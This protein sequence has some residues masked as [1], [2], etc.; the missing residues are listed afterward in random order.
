MGSLQGPI[1]CLSVRAKQTGVHPL[2]VNGPLMKAKI[3]RS[4]FW[5][6]RG[7]N[8][9]RINVCQQLCMQMYKKVQCSFSSSSNGNGSM[10]ENFNENDEDYVNSSI[11]EVGV[12]NV[13]VTIFYFLNSV[14]FNAFVMFGSAFGKCICLSVILSTLEEVKKA[15]L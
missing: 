10:V 14:V 8:G 5:G 15:N 2:P 7:V 12:L 6:I 4:G 9:T 13:I 1:I 11:V 3:L